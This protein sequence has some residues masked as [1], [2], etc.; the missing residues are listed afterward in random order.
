MLRLLHDV[1]QR[2]CV[3]RQRLVLVSQHT[4]QGKV[5][6]VIAGAREQLVESL[7]QLVVLVCA[8]S[9][10]FKKKNLRKLSLLLYL[11]MI[12]PIFSLLLLLTQTGR[13]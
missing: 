12:I 11:F 3:R 4:F 10:F 6:D 1:A 5:L 13:F 7:L 8:L 2:L 9:R